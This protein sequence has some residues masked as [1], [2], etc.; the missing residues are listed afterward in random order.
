MKSSDLICLNDLFSNVSNHAEMFQF[1]A[2]EGK[3]RPYFEAL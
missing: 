2:R 1:F 3:P